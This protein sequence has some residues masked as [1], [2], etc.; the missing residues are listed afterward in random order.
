MVGQASTTLTLPPGSTTRLQQVLQLGNTTLW[1][2]EVPYLYRLET[3][4]YLA[5]PGGGAP[6][7]LT[8]TQ[9]TPLGLRAAVWSPSA[10]FQLNGAK[11]PLQGFSNHQS[12]GGAGVALPRRVDAF[13]VA[14]LKALGANLWRGSYPYSAALMEAADRQGM[15]LWVENRMLHYQVQPVGAGG[16]EDPPP[17]PGY[18][19]PQLLQD[20]QD[21]AIAAR[22]H[23]ST[24]IY[25]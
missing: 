20:A 8:D 10:G 19:D 16:G 1:N 7:A 5:P 12:W 9:S 3:S 18:A 15:L 21:M 22:N 11:L 17:P 4:L 6:P 13:R 24:A 14:A 2:T 25:R 23:P